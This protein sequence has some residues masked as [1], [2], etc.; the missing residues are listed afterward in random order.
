MNKWQ[1]A[2]SNCA[3][4]GFFYEAYCK[5]FMTRTLQNTLLAAILAGSALADDGLDEALAKLKKTPRR[6]NY[7]RR[8]ELYD[9]EM[10]V[11]TELSDEEKMLDQKLRQ[12]EKEMENKAQI[13]SQQYSAPQMV[14]PRVQVQENK[15]WLTP[16]LLDGTISKEAGL[17]KQ[18]DDS[19]VAAELD[20]QKSIRMERE[21][22]E[23]ANAKQNPLF[24]Q[25][26]QW[27][28]S[29]TKLHS[30]ERS[31]E[32]IIS[33]Q[34]DPASAP[35]DNNTLNNYFSERKERPESPFSL[36]HK[37]REEQEPA[38]NS[39]TRSKNESGFGMPRQPLSQK[40]SY[41]SPWK[42][43]TAPQPSEP[44]WEQKK[45]QPLQPLERIRKSS[46]VYKRDPFSE[47]LMPTLKKS[48][49]D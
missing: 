32:E 21:A 9:Q 22:L 5:I 24:G 37:N 3:V 16:E 44:S 13:V 42:T 34:K 38:F 27:D 28:N 43:A 12:L 25:S 17:D 19:W 40:P 14:M 1:P 6:G 20:R 35:R 41:E 49:W 18:D 11:P 29:A 33:V 39:F 48:I 10:T 8:A 30:Y 46:P 2:A 23:Q 31:L 47:D 15:N 36:S 45:S 26:L 7:S 4:D